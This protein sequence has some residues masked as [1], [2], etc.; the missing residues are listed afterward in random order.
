MA[1]TDLLASIEKKVT[2]VKSKKEVSD[3]AEAAY[4]K[5]SS[6]LSI[7]KNEL[8]ALRNEVHAALGNVFSDSSRVRQA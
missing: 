8:E 3:T 7:A 6:E 5:A 2:E 4:N 1:L